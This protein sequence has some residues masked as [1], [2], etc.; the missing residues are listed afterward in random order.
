MCC[1]VFDTI[2]SLDLSLLCTLFNAHVLN[3][4]YDAM[5]QEESMC[6][7]NNMCLITLELRMLHICDSHRHALSA[8]VALTTR[9]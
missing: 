8:V 1:V 2:V 4:I 3:K 6:L 9:S 5:Y 7:I